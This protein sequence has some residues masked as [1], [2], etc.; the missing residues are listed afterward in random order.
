[1]VHCVAENSISAAKAIMTAIVK[2]MRAFIWTLAFMFLVLYAVG[3][4]L[5]QCVTDYKVA[6]E[7]DGSASHELQ[8][9]FGTLPGTMLSLFQA[10]TDGQEWREMLKPLISEI[11]PWMAVPFCMYISFMAFALLILARGCVLHKLSAHVLAVVGTRHFRI[12]RNILTGIFVDS[13]L[14]NAQE[15]KRRYLLQE[16]GLLFREAEKDGSIVGRNPRSLLR[17]CLYREA[18][19]APKNP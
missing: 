5:T 2:G 7:N 13:A 12:L 15:E 3:V 9:Y 16:V 10:I 17:L 14:E 18:T 4:F 6:L 8:D 19:D 11:S 1:M